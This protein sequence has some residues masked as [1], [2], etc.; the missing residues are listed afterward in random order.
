MKGETNGCY[1]PRRIT[2]VVHVMLL[3]SLLVMEAG[4]YAKGFARDFWNKPARGNFIFFPSLEGTAFRK[5]TP[6]RSIN[7]NTPQ[8]AYTPLRDLKTESATNSVTK[9]PACWCVAYRLFSLQP[10][11]PM[12]SRSPSLLKIYVILPGR[13]Q[14]ILLSETRA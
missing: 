14:S 1:F 9:A 7:T 6:S 5:I 4:V 2:H 8:T 10:R 13:M 12:P 3:V 11:A